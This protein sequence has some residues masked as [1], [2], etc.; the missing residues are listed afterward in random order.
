MTAAVHA[1]FNAV[2]VNVQT[3]LCQ[4][5]T[6][7]ERRAVIRNF[8][9]YPLFRRSCTRPV[10]VLALCNLFEDGQVHACAEH[11]RP[12]HLRSGK[13]ANGIKRSLVMIQADHD[14][15]LDF[16]RFHFLGKSRLGCNAGKSRL[17][18]NAIVF[19]AEPGIQ[20]EHQKIKV[21]V[22]TAIKTARTKTRKLAF[23]F[24]CNKIQI[25]TDAANASCLR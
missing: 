21:L 25:R 23:Y 13:A 1:R 7:N 14:V 18:K 4:I 20:R 22:A 12:R 24:V 10:K 16:A 17:C 6:L 15:C 8:Q 9:D 19:H 5:A 11:K 3:L 2:F